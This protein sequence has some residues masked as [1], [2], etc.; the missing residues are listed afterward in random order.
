MSTMTNPT[1]VQSAFRGR[2]GDTVALNDNTT[3]AANL[4]T[5]W[6]QNVDTTFRVRIEV[7]ETATANQFNTLAPQLQYNLNGAG[8]VN[9]TTTS[10]V[11]RA[12]VSGQF[13]E[14]DATTN[15][16]ASSARGFVASTGSEDGLAGSATLSN[17]HT[18]AEFSIQ[19][20]SANVAN[21]D[22]IQLRLSDA[23]AALNTYSQTPTVTAIG[24]QNLTP[25]LFSSATVAFFAATV[26]VG[27]V[28]LDPPLFTNSNAFY[29]PTVE[30]PGA[31][32]DLTPTLVT[33]TNAFYAP[34]VA[35]TYALTPA[36]VTNTQSFHAPTVAPG[37]VGL[38]PGLYSNTNTFY[39]PTVSLGGGAQDLTP[40]LYAN[41]NAFYS[42]TVDGGVVAAPV[43]APITH[44]DVYAISKQ[45]KAKD[46][47]KQ[48]L[49]RMLLLLG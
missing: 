7:E 19:L 1:Y 15:I 17:Q 27:A 20:L 33:N 45:D 29:S 48:E 4:N 36:L 10:S 49:E 37:A 46:H 43:V 2:S 35:S 28:N 12:V 40:S 31:A 8:W 38:T 39:S 41:D 42:P 6:S 3:W 47:K 16:L 9:V 26:T 5:N 13:N 30:Q 25:S 32:Q 18:E 23:G 24:A 34:T 11:V 22:S 14:G 44:W 21:N